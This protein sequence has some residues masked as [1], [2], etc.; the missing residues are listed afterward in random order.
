M[1][2]IGLEEQLSIRWR[3]TEP[4]SQGLLHLYI[5]FHKD[6]DDHCTPYIDNKYPHHENGCVIIGNSNT[7]TIQ[8]YVFLDEPMI[9]PINAY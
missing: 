1:N 8:P 5:D 6:V 7:S 2:D 9:E 3:T 4:D